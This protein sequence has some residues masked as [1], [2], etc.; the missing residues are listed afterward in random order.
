MARAT[1]SVRARLQAIAEGKPAEA[2]RRP[3]VEL[4]TVEK[5][6][7]DFE[8]WHRFSSLTDGEP[9]LAPAEILSPLP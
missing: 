5:H 6:S 4:T 9:M 2:S 7:R 1:T 8:A 3:I